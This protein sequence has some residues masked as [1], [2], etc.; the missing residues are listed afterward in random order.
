MTQHDRLH[1]VCACGYTADNLGFWLDHALAC[2][3]DRRREGG[4]RTRAQQEQLAA[5]RTERE[6]EWQ[7]ASEE[8]AIRSAFGMTLVRSERSG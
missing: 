8:A 4:T 1:F 7:E 6:Q 5:M 3:R 2:W